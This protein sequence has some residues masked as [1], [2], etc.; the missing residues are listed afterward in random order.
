[1][2]GSKFVARCSDKKEIWARVKVSGNC[3]TATCLIIL[4]VSAA[5]IEMSALSVSNCCLR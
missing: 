2:I 3:S 4:T 5:K 1:M